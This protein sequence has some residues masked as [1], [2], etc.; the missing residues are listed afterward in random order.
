MENGRLV[1]KKFNSTVTHD[2]ESHNNSDVFN[3]TLDIIVGVQSRRKLTRIAAVLFILTDGGIL[4]RPLDPSLM[5]YVNRKHFDGEKQTYYSLLDALFS[6]RHD[7]IESPLHI[8]A[9][10]LNKF[11]VVVESGHFASLSDSS[12]TRLIMRVHQ[13]GD[14]IGKKLKQFFGSIRFIIESYRNAKTEFLFNYAFSYQGGLDVIQSVPI[15]D[16]GEWF[17]V[18][19]ID[20]SAGEDFTISF[21]DNNVTGSDAV[22]LFTL[23]SQ[24]QTSVS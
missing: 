5:K 14:T 9:I 12:F 8:S 16:H 4:E 6:S 15:G 3:T 19:R 1:Q 20:F 18:G 7:D 24:N 22:K 13:P 11:T 17:A 23:S 21:I 10:E 2:S